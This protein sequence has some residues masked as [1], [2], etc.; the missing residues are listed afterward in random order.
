MTGQPLVHERIVRGQQIQR[1]SVVAHDAGKEQFGFPTECLAQVVVE[2]REHQKVRR[3]FVQIAKL[4]PLPGEFGHQGI[5]P[6]VHDH[7]TD[8]SFE[9]ARLAQSAGDRQVQQFIVRNAAPQEERQ[10]RANSRSLMRWAV[11]GAMLAGSRST[12]NTNDGLARIRATPARMPALK[13]PPFF[14]ASL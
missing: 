12:R 13:S 10:A 3:D 9:H 1:T 14:R 6:F 11:P 8:L 2:I 5:G 7:A 4:E